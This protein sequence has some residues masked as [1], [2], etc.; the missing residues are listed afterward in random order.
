M[1][2]SA[3]LKL[4]IEGMTCTGCAS[5]LQIALNTI[6][7]IHTEVSFASESAEVTIDDSVDYDGTV[8]SIQILIEKKGY[9]TALSPEDDGLNNRQSVT[10]QSSKNPHDS[11]VKT[12]ELLI[13]GATC[14]SCVNKIEKALNALPNV[15][16]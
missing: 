13:E 15:Q 12:Q 10:L 9:K 8:K 5:R 6:D 14:A 11:Q 2:L 4:P 7:G 16:Q 3:N 1:S